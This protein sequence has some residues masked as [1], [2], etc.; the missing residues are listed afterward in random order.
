[1]KIIGHL[2]SK[3]TVTF[4]VD[5]EEN[6]TFF[7]TTSYWLRQAL[8]EKNIDTR[9]F[10]N[11]SARHKPLIQMKFKIVEDHGIE[12]ANSGMIILIEDKDTELPYVIFNSSIYDLLKDLSNGL[13]NFKNGYAKGYFTLSKKNKT[14]MLEYISRETDLHDIATLY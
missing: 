3:T 14:Y 5:K 1:M 11:F 9:K 4:K 8:E 12:S 13:L 7:E 10:V 2:K 6:P